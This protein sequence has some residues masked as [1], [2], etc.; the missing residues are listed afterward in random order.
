VVFTFLTLSLLSLSYTHTYTHTQFFPPKKSI[1]KNLGFPSGGKQI[2]YSLV[3]WWIDPEELDLG[4][5][6]GALPSGMTGVSWG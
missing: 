6:A 2:L 5:H 4:P 1:L 3:Q